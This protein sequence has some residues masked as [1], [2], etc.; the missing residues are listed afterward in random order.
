MVKNKQNGQILIEPLVAIVVVSSTLLAILTLTIFALRI[1]SI[2]VRITKAHHLAQESFEALRSI[3]DGEGSL[4]KNTGMSEYVYDHWNWDPIPVLQKKYFRVHEETIGTKQWVAEDLSSSNAIEDLL[5]PMNIL[6]K[7][8]YNEAQQSWDP[9]TGTEPTTTEF[10]YRQIIINDYDPDGTEGPEAPIP[11]EKEVF[12]LITFV[13]R[14]NTHTV[15]YKTM[16]T[17]WQWFRQ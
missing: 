9:V 4:K 2:N 11:E 13:E 6:Y 8:F 5:D 12:V 1:S 14:G 16:L 17:N 10:F 7:V 3:R 15:S